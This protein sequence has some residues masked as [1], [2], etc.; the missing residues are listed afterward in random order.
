MA[1]LGR[2]LLAARTEARL[3]QRQVRVAIG[4]TR[5]AYWLY[6]HGTCR[7]NEHRLDRLAVVLSIDRAELRQLAGYGPPAMIPRQREPQ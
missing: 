1:D 2:R 6:E 4:V 7:P 3:S 5:G